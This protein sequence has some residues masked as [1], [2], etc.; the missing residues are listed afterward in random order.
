MPEM[1]EDGLGYHLPKQP[2]KHEEG[3]RR[4]REQ[5][6]DQRPVVTIAISA[7]LPADS[8]RLAGEDDKHA[9]AL[10]ESE[11]TLPPILVHRSTMRVID[12]MHRLHAARLRGQE[13]IEVQFYDGAEEDAFVL[14]VRANITHGLPLSLS[15]RSAAAARIARSHPEWSDRMIA[16]TAGLSPKTVGAIRQRLTEEIPQLDNRV[17]GDGK[18]RPVNSAEGRRIAGQLITNEPDATLRAVAEVAGI[19]PT[20]VR[21]VRERLRR[22]EQPELPQQPEPTPHTKHSNPNTTA[23]RSTAAV[24]TSIL[25]NLRKDPSL[26]FNEAGRTLL[27][28][29]DANAI[30]PDEWGR[31]IDS[32][33]THCASMIAD[34]AKEYAN[35]WRRV[36]TQV[37][38]RGSN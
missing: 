19:S 1:P 37:K 5:S 11:A 23:R 22:G 12:G 20:T 2:E 32:V 16:A 35:A 36:A 6:L 9:H 34:A 25:P 31:L 26:R 17:G 38:R 18:T 7:L 30:E 4:P 21:D 29:L 24:R 13:K 27:R 28:L 3:V 14:A 8:P 33:P 15:D 10:A